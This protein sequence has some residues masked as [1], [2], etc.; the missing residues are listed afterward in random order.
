M[1]AIPNINVLIKPA[2]G[3]CNLQC[4]YCFYLDLI[5]NKCHSNG[6][7]MPLE[8]LE[9]LVQSVL[10]YADDTASFSFQGGEPMLAG[11]DFY[12]NL[13]VLQKK[14]NTKNIKIKNA[15][16]TNGT[17]INLE[18]AEFFRAH[19]F[20]VGVSLDGM[21][22]IH[23]LNRVDHNGEGTYLRVIDAIKILDEFQVEYNILCVV[24]RLVAKHPEKTYR[25]FKKQGFQYLQFIPCLDGL[26]K[27]PGMDNY[28]L[29]P[30]L[31]GNFLKRL[32]D[33]WLKDNLEGK[34]ISIR[35][36]DNILGMLL[37]YPPES[38]DM[39]GKCKANL[40]V[41]S[42]GSVYPCDFYVLDQWKLGVIGNDSILDMLF[43][44]T[45][46]KFE[47][48]SNLRPQACRDCEFYSLCRG[49]CRRNYEPI[50]NEILEK[51]YFCEAYRDFYRYAIPGFLKLAKKCVEKSSERSL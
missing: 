51:N 17:L 47:E 39:R 9:K 30:Q 14:Y 23:N 5:D 12:R 2:S 11:L 46:K 41:E 35:M 22:G 45:A 42:D 16:Q 48:I 7:F 49:G 32:F 40:V 8:T 43:G 1:L 10:E 50:R 34:E 28:S 25:F 21:E 44:Q 36:F 29:S 38:C 13:L 6:G 27:Q 4:K 15:I 20:L 18:W 33:L 24:T 26:E 19:H 31:Y 3:N 37:G